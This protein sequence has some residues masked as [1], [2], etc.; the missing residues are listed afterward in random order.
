MKAD[1]ERTSN[2]SAEELREFGLIAGGHLFFQALSAACRLDI[3]SYFERH[4]DASIGELAT[5]LRA[6]EHGVR[7][8]VTTCEALNLLRRSGAGYRNKPVASKYLLKGSS[9]NIHPL[10]EAHRAIIYPGVAKL[11]ES[12]QEARAVGLDM[13]PGSGQTL[14]AR[15]ESN[16]ELERTFQDWM[17]NTSGNNNSHFEHAHELAGARHILDVGGGDGTN[18][19]ALCEAFPDAR[20]TIFDL[21]AV[22]EIAKRNVASRS[23]ADRIS[24]TSGDFLKDAFPSDIDAIL[25]GHIATI[26]SPKTN[27]MLFEKLYRALPSGGT[28]VVYGTMSEDDGSGPFH[29]V[30]LSLYFLALASHEGAVHRWSDYREWLPRAG[31]SDLRTHRIGD[32]TN[33]GLIIAKKR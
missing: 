27:E 2:I 9:E 24:V 10:L 20:V 25:L 17:Q 12:V 21:P 13:L 26:F 32:W 6:P 28:L 22:C 29:S 7:T 16:S 3:F 31:F 1:E 11:L 18:A 5:H 30:A 23:R 19:L 14:Y 8:L 4:P 15:L 33:Q